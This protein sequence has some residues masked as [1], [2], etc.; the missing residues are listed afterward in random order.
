MRFAGEDQL[1]SVRQ[2]RTFVFCQEKERKDLC[3]LHKRRIVKLF[4]TDESKACCSI[5][6]AKTEK[7]WYNLRN[8]RHL[9]NLVLT[10]APLWQQ[11]LR[12]VK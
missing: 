1:E 7:L 8:A 6:I 3:V 12:E 5:S 10:A 2:W 11:R 4:K 9:R